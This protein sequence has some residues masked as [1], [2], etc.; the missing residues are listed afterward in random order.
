MTKEAF[1]KALDWSVSN[2]GPELLDKVRK[3]VKGSTIAFEQLEDPDHYPH[4][5]KCVREM[6]F[7][8]KPRRNTPVWEVMEKSIAIVH[9]EMFER[10]RQ[11]GYWKY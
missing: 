8:N 1:E 7:Q 9:H 3:V 6:V 10:A 2:N 5:V 11:L 4:V